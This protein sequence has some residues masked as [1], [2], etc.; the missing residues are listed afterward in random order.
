MRAKKRGAHSLCTP[1][2][3]DQ[4][5]GEECGRGA[6]GGAQPPTCFFSVENWSFLAETFVE[7]HVKI[8]ISA[9]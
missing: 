5:P 2:R 6:P 3:Y 1:L 7:N 8:I 9:N 4:A